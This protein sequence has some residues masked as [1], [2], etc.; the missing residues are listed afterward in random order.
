MSRALCLLATLVLGSQLWAGDPARNT[1]PSYS[2]ASIVNSATNVIGA[3]AP[4]TIATIYGSNLAYSTAAVQ[5]DDVRGGS[6]PKTLAGTRVIV[7]GITASLF[8][9]SPTQI[10]FLIPSLLLPGDFDVWI[11]REGTQG[12]VARITL[13]DV[14]PALFQV[15]A[16][17]IIAVHVDAS[18]VTVDAPARPGEVVILYAAGLGRTNPDTINGQVATLAAPIRR[19]GDLTVTLG[20]VAV[21]PSNIAYAGLAPGFAGLYQINLK[22]PDVFEPNPEIRI[23]FGDQI[24]PAALKLPARQ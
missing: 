1:A 18:L 3:L 6:L 17:T 4:N 24:S 7:G 9:V 20:G 16:N 23:A 14:A 21:D 2:A 15:N 22:L 5:P 13:L 8:Y 12:P 19:L 11:A 10:N